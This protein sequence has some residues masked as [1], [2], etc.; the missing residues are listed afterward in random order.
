MSQVLRQ[1]AVDAEQL[2]QLEASATA[3]GWSTRHY[4]DSIQAGH[5]FYGLEQ[6]ALGC[7]VV[8]P[9]L[10]EAE[11]LNIFIAAGQQGRGL[12]FVLL[13]GLMQ[14]LKQHGCHKLF[15]EVRASNHPARKLYSNCGFQEIGVRKNYYSST[16]GEREHAILMEAVL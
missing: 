15:L 10:D 13:S 16:N 1:Q 8:M 11:L 12:G 2:A 5:V 14:D 9:L 7:A 3:H 4:Q 6:Q